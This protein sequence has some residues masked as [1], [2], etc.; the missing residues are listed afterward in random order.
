MCG[1]QEIKNVE[2][3]GTVVG[4]QVGLVAG[5]S[6]DDHLSLRPVP[7]VPGQKRCAVDIGSGWQGH[8]AVSGASG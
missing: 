4:D 1:N 3:F 2:S 8:E 6:L 5:V 7:A